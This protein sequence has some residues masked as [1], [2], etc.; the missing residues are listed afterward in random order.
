MELIDIVP[1]FNLYEEYWRIYTKSDILPAQYVSSEAHIEHCIVGDGSEIYGKLY[2]CVIGPGVRVEEDVEIYD[3]IIMEGCV[4]KKGSRIRKAIL[5]GNS[6]VGE[7]CT[8]GIGEYA[9]SLYNKKVYCF[10]LVTVAENSVIPD[11]VTIGTNVAI[12]GVTT[13]EDYPGGHLVS[14]GYIIKGGGEL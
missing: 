8:I 6:V 9:E 12:S 13:P 4:I 7:G 3:S 14:G 5:A 11:W 10:D 2:N 1:V